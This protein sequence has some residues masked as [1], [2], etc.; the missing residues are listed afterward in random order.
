MNC[1]AEGCAIDKRG[2][3]RASSTCVGDRLRV[4]RHI[5]AA[6]EQQVVLTDII[7]PAQTEVLG[8]QSKFDFLRLVS[9]K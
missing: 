4:K 7:E 5:V 8:V 1:L 3:K 9:S 6:A 2:V